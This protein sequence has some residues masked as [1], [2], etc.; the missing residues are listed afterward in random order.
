MVVM[1][2]MMAML[3]IGCTDDDN[4]YCDASGNDDKENVHVEN[5]NDYDDNSN[6]GG[7]GDEHM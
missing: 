7:D 5:G 2:M 1:T 6:D 3:E 4:D